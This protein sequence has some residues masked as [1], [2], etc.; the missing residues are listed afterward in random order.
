MNS[1][2]SMGTGR[3][4]ADRIRVAGCLTADARLVPSTGAMP[5]AFLFLDFGPAE[6][7]PYRARVDLGVDLA[8]HMAAEA[9]LP[10]LRTGAVVSVAGRALRLRTDHDAAVLSVID[11]RDVL[12]LQD[13]APTPPPA[14][15]STHAH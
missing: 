10:Q 5:H 12:V 4:I 13:P 8:D 15:E 6:G 14:K 3:L 11:A 7:L 9:L 1:P 2:T